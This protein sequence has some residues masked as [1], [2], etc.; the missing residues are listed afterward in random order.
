MDDINIARVLFLFS[1][2]F[3]VLISVNAGVASADENLVAIRGENVTLS[4]VLLQN[5]TYGEPVPE[6]EIYFFDQTNNQLLGNAITDSNGLAS[7]I[8][9]IPS[10]YL[11]GPTIINATFYGNESQFLAS[12]F[13]NIVLNILA[14]TEILLHETPSLPCFEVLRE[15][16][17]IFPL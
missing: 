9:D 2:L 12:S 8:W 15:G 5:G 16:H 4:V 13:Q 10:D 1:I 3:L 6:Q 17:T 14:D 11:L 7:I